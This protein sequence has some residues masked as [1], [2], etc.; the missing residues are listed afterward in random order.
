MKD[1][2]IIIIRETD[3]DSTDINALSKAQS[4]RI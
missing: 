4:P 2:S 3:Q 1:Y